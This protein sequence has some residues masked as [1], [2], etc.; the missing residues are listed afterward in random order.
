VQVVSRSD[1]RIEFGK[2]GLRVSSY[3]DVIP[4]ANSDKNAGGI[5][6]V[7]GYE[8]GADN[9][10]LV[11]VD[12]ED[13]GGAKGGIDYSKKVSERLVWSFFEVERVGSA[14]VGDIDRR[15]RGTPR[16][17]GYVANPVE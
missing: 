11:V 15:I 7:D 1:Q 8:V 13:K 5:V 10:Q 14:D 2:V 3:N 4:L 9:L 6:A 12:G 16:P 17:F